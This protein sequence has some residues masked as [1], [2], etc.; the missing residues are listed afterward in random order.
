MTYFIVVVTFYP[1]YI[2]LHGLDL[3]SQQRGLRLH[4]GLV[5]NHDSQLLAEV[6]GS[7]QAGLL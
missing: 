5:S 2:F 4:P 7:R 6:H 1:V 3:F